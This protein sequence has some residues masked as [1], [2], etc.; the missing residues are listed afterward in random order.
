MFEK[1]KGKLAE[2]G[3][4]ISDEAMSNISICNDWYKGEMTAFHARHSL[5]GFNY[6][7]LRLNFAKRVCA[8]EASLCEIIN[9]QSEQ[10]DLT[11]FVNDTFKANQFNVMY[12]E[13]LEG[14]SATGTA[15]AYIYLKNASLYDDGKIRGGDI[16][17]NYCKA[18]NIIPMTVINGDVKECAFIGESI[19]NGK[20]VDQ[21][22]IYRL[23]NGKYEM[24]KVSIDKDGEAVVSTPEVLGDVKPFAIMRLAEINN[25]DHMEGYGYPKLMD[26]I[27]YLKGL[28]LAYNVL[29]GDVDKADKIILINEIFGEKNSV[30]EWQLSEEQKKYFISVGEKMPDADTLIYEHNPTIRVD[31][32]QPAF[33]L[34]FG[35]LSQQYGY[36][37]KKYTFEHGTV[38]TAT[39]YI[40]EKSAEMQSLN[41]QRYQSIQYIEDL[42]KAMRW[43]ANNYQDKNFDIDVPLNIDFDDSIITDKQAKLDSM[44]ADAITFEIP[45]IKKLYLMEKYGWT[46]EETQV[47]LDETDMT[48]E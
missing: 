39:Q 18:E 9:I 4:S 26:S 30:G 43:F 27:P 1:T 5:G 7:L 36:G 45:K 47:Y 22:I 38:T 20:R 3:V 6:D 8:D 11:Q 41:K 19:Q 17:I 48:I 10:K 34:L 40:L 25:K 37:N 24:T 13:Q 35:L 44:R 33:E 15:G 28:E 21:T 31:S 42:S 32:L 29:Y 14:M 2:L 16:K 23:K 46:E 12:R